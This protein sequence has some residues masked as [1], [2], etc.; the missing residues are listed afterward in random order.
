MAQVVNNQ[1]PVNDAPPPVG[2][3]DPACHEI[4]VGEAVLFTKTDGKWT[5]PVRE[6]SK[7]IPQTLTVNRAK[8][9]AQG[10]LGLDVVG[11]CAQ[12]KGLTQVVH[13][14][15]V[16]DAATNHLKLGVGP[17]VVLTGAV[18]FID[19]CDA[20][21]TAKKVNYVWGQQAARIQQVRGV[22]ETTGGMAATSVGLINTLSSDGFVA[23]SKASTV[24]MS[25]LGHISTAMGALRY[26]SIFGLCGM[27]IYRSSEITG[28]FA[29]KETDEARVAYLNEFLELTSEDREKIYDEVDGAKE[30]P[31]TEKEFMLLSEA[32]FAFVSSK[33]EGKH[34][35]AV[36][37]EIAL[38]K[39]GK[40]K[41][42]SDRIGGQA[43]SKLKKGEAAEEII[44]AAKEG[45]N[46][47]FRMNVIV[48]TICMAA[49]GVGIASDIMTGGLSQII[50]LGLSLAISAGW[51]YV[52][53]M[54][55]LD[56]FNSKEEGK[57]DKLFKFMINV[58]VLAV[59]ACAIFYTAGTPL[60]LMAAIST[61]ILLVTNFGIWYKNQQ[62]K[63]KSEP[64][65]VEAAIDALRMPAGMDTVPIRADLTEELLSAGDQAGET[66]EGG[67]AASY[68]PPRLQEELRVRN[69]SASSESLDRI[70][71][72]STPVL[73]GRSSSISTI[74]ARSPSAIGE[75]TR[76]TPIP[77]A[78]AR[79]R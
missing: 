64:A 54:M 63:A 60:I 36:L 30:E 73:R 77:T 75:E 52:D 41:D 11:A 8:V 16:G 58:I 47:K 10:Y 14:Q 53:G 65:E 19:G 27:S 18:N 56:G 39:M 48:M 23:A 28:E 34:P 72:V 7:E 51:F 55:V 59:S 68:V 62:M 70:R 3:G 43:L 66:E 25:I 57:Y 24:A 78:F 37:R 76:L 5:P 67:A 33:G 71:D 31:L 44:K 50:T 35:N 45:I 79:I 2:G 13:D 69:R 49:T 20:H 38:R 61:G 32:D 26:L 74:V 21:A 40:E 15:S 29:K 22:A 9:A 4:R 17:V 42:L 12:A 6:F 1:F 46:S